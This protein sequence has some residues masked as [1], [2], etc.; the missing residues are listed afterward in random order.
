MNLASCFCKIMNLQIQEI[1][2][3]WDAD[4]LIE[5]APKFIQMLQLSGI[6]SENGL[7]FISKILEILDHSINEVIVEWTKVFTQL[8]DVLS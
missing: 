7:V 5:V 6:N 3:W 1:I 4:I 8:S 2:T